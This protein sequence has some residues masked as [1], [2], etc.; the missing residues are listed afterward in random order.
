VLHSIPDDEPVTLETCRAL[1]SNKEHKMLHLVG[2]YM[3]ITHQAARSHEHEIHV[4]CDVTLGRVVSDVSENPSAFT[5]KGQAVPRKR[6][7][8]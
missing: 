4:F 8:A 5:F 7:T 6:R 1:P 2:I 3:M